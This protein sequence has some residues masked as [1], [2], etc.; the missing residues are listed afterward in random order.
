MTPPAHAALANQPSRADVVA[1]IDTLMSSFRYD[2]KE[3]WLGAYTMLARLRD[4][5]RRAMR[6]YGVA[7][8]LVGVTVLPI[9]ALGYWHLISQPTFPLWWFWALL[10]FAGLPSAIA[11]VVLNARARRRH[12]LLHLQRE[13]E[14]ACK[15]FDEVAQIVSPAAD[16]AGMPST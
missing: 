9:W 2:P 8:L 16:A 10:V 5:L 11:G 4:D 1:A 3:R 14:E 12:P 7:R 15:Y 13:I 6:P